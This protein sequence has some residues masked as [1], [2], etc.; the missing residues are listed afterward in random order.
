MYNLFGNVLKG[1][2][3]RNVSLVYMDTDSF[4]L[5]YKKFGVYADANTGQM[6]RYM[7]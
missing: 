4:L 6:A 2:Y 5:S 7:D 1:K 3:S